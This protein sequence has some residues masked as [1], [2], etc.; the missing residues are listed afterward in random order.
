MTYY[1][2]MDGVLADFHSA[3]TNDKMTALKRES[4]KN[5]NPFI[6]NVELVKKLIASK[7]V[8]YILTKAANEE[9][10]LGKIDWLQRYI[11]EFNIKNFICITKGRKIDYIKEPGMLIDDDVKNLRPW[12]KA[13][14][15]TYFVEIKGA[16]IIF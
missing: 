10:R 6:V 15:P 11:P 8:V 12:E 2:D 4:M 16:E 13:G 7:A 14:Y 3:Y 9:G 1:F 5:L